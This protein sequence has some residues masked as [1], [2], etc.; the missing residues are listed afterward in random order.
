M[1]KEQFEK[2]QALA[3]AMAPYVALS[4]MECPKGVWQTINITDSFG[5]N[6]HIRDRLLRDILVDY[7]NKRLANYEQQMEE[8]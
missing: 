2:A 4:K 7:A 3:E 8:I 1:T 6:V 5:I